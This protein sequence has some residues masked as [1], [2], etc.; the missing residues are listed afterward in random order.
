MILSASF[1][2]RYDFFGTTPLRHPNY[3]VN[4]SNLSLIHCRQDHLSEPRFELRTAANG[5]SELTT[6]QAKCTLASAIDQE[7]KGPTRN[8]RWPW[9]HREQDDSPLMPTARIRR[10]TIALDSILK[11]ALVSPMTSLNNLVDCL[12]SLGRR[13]DSHLIWGTTKSFLVPAFYISSRKKYLEGRFESGEKIVV[14][15]FTV[16]QKLTR[17]REFSAAR[18][19]KLVRRDGKRATGS[20]RRQTPLDSLI[21]RPSQSSPSPPPSPSPPLPSGRGGLVRW[22]KWR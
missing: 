12:F 1:Y 14:H 4:Q 22:V 15:W 18:D 21:G 20:T 6:M 19:K 10:I 5:V 7:L 9:W 8:G 17:W 2:Y 16:S 3:S 11:M 13:L